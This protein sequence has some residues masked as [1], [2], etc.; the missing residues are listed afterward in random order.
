MQIFIHNGTLKLQK[1]TVSTLHKTL[2][3]NATVANILSHQEE[4]LLL[5]L[6][7]C[8][9]IL[10]SVAFTLLESVAFSIKGVRNP[11]RINTVT[12]TAKIAVS[13]VPDELNL[14]YPRFAFQ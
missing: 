4:V 11:I 7:V 1:K 3:G 6:T 14:N 5:R 13:F 8:L 2:K 9:S 10:D 12:R